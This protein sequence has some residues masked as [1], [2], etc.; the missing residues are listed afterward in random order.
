[1]GAKDGDS[2][3]P[4]F[5][6]IA[7]LK[8]RRDE[9]ISELEK[10]RTERLEEAERQRLQALEKRRME[11]NEAKEV[12]ITDAKSCIASIPPLDYAT[13]GSA[14]FTSEAFA[15]FVEEDSSCLPFSPRLLAS[16]STDGT[17]CLWDPDTGGLITM[18]E[19]SEGYEISAVAFSKDG[20]L[21]ACGVGDGIIK[22]YD[23]NTMNNINDLEIHE[24]GVTF[25]AFS[26]TSDALVSSD[27]QGAVYVW[28]LATGEA[29]EL[30][31]PRGTAVQTLAFSNDGTTL[32]AGC[33]DGTINVWDLKKQTLVSHHSMEDE[34]ESLVFHRDKVL[35]VSQSDS[36]IFLNTTTEQTGNAQLN[37]QICSIASGGKP[38]FFALGTGEGKIFVSFLKDYGNAPEGFLTLNGHTGRVRCLHASGMN[39]ELVSCGEGSDGCEIFLW[40]ATGGTPLRKFEGQGGAIL[41]VALSPGQSDINMVYTEVRRLIEAVEMELT[42]T[43]G[44]EFELS[45][46]NE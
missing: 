30:C 9:K 29:H 13:S 39:G 32:A 16:A 40:N 10:E 18:L 20:G 42:S 21:L 33:N 36:V 38:K 15:W 11:L 45:W 43:N 27:W 31:E 1:M 25:L 14:K 7:E 24:D 19:D 17:V 2:E 23:T 22:L 41:S 3:N 44:I 35:V 37:N 5:E 8:T 34:V 46:T 6:A 26:P 28:N 4:F 12:L